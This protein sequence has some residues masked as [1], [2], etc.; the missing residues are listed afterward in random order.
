VANA[1]VNLQPAGPPEAN[2]A[3]KLLGVPTSAAGAA[4]GLAGQA[5][6]A[7]WMAKQVAKYG[8]PG[9]PNPTLGTLIDLGMCAKEALQ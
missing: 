7:G 3:A 5:A 8:R 6:G 2:C 1:V 9:P 4:M